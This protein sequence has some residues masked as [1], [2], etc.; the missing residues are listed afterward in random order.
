MKGV[1]YSLS[2]D[3][4]TPIAGLKELFAVHRA[5][6]DPGIAHAPHALVISDS[7]LFCAIDVAFPISIKKSRVLIV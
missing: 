2:A 1:A 6:A 5:F 4:A 3:R 7:K